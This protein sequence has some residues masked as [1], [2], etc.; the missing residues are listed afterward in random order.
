MKWGLP[1]AATV[2]QLSWDLLAF[3]EAQESVNEYD[4]GL[5]AV[6]Y[7]TDYLMDAHP[8]DNVI[9][10]VFGNSETDFEYYGPPEEYE[11]WASGPKV[12]YYCTE[13][14]PCSEIAAQ[15]A[16]ALASAAILFQDEDPTY[17]TELL[18][19]AVQLYE[20]AS[21]FPGSLVDHVDVNTGFRTHTEWYPSTS[22]IDELSLAAAWLY[23]STGQSQYL[24]DARQYY[25]G[26][27]G[28]N[29]AGWGYSWD[30]KGPALHVIMSELDSGYSSDY[31]TNA[32]SYFRQWMPGPDRTVDMTPLGLSYRYY[33]G[34]LRYSANTAFL[35]LAYAR[36]QMDSEGDTDFAS[37]LV[38]YARGQIDY[39]LGDSGRSW[40]VGFGDNY[41][42]SPYHKSSYN[43]ILHYPMRG[44][45]W[46]DQ[47]ADFLYSSTTNEHILYGA[48]VGGPFAD[49]SFVDNR[50]DY[51][52]TEVTQDYNA[53]FTGA[54]SG[55]IHFYGGEPFTDCGLDLGWD[56]PGAGT[57]PEWPSDDHY[58]QC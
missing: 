41:P 58:H 13:T 9:V 47:E 23:K 40:L 37:E 26:S 33:W 8:E 19:H 3:R 51:E 12:P 28:P 15:T 43:S 10:V 29:Y 17:S 55:L 31:D 46:E 48:L 6:K 24:A 56:Y 36:A 21:D 2:M 7:G 20:F 27:G 45:A 18:T 34:S 57:P 14:Y 39:M 30:E 1:L 32:Q 38:V 50:E 53:G 52:Y 44:Q 54:V 42:L 16:A 35:A 49:D 4:E 22:Y 5:E 25:F 11:Q